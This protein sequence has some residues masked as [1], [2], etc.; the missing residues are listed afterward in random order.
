MSFW[1][2][3]KKQLV[4]PGERLPSEN[5]ERGPLGL[6]ARETEVFRLLL[7]GY[8]LKETADLLGVKSSTVNTHTTSIYKKLNVTSR[9]ELIIRYRD[10][11]KENT[12]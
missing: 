3:L 7:E 10:Y 6:T 11:E 9:A 5:A 2:R 4:K 1:E 8:T 12:K